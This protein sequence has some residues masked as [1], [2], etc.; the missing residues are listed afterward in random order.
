MAYTSVAMTLHKYNANHKI[1]I[2]VVSY[3]VFTKGK[4]IYPFYVCLPSRTVSCL[5]NV[6]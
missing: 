1:E 3:S 2:F 4:N 6:Q 5:C